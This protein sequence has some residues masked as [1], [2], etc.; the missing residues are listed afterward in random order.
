[1]AEKGERL[2]S[3]DNRWLKRFRAALAGHAEKDGALLG[4]EGPRL[5]EEALRSGVAAEALL[6]SDSG[7]RH[8]LSLRHCLHAKLRMLRTSDRL[9]AA[10]AGTETPQGVAALVE[11]PHWRMP[12][13]LGAAAL[14]VA[15]AGV[16]DPGNVGAIIR[17]AEAFGASGVVACAGS[18]NPLGVKAVRASAGSVFRL[19]TLSGLRPAD[20]QAE[21][22][23]RGLPQFAAVT[24]EG[25]APVETDLAQPC[26]LWIGSEGSGL[27]EEIQRATD[28][29]IRI[30]LRPT[31]DSLNAASA[32]TVLLYE[33]ARQRGRAGRLPEAER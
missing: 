33:A 1:M 10:V 19:P 4:V 28:A 16:Q 12:D 26:V 15:L 14:V 29:S 27:P 30:P 25:P 24:A 17:A 22:R 31:V 7:E 18:A 3:R 21:L 32:A 20:L 23:K 11:P 6:V 8:L 5:V 9:F 13:L 2:T